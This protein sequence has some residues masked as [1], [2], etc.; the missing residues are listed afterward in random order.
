MS[1]SLKEV[2]SRQ[3]LLSATAILVYLALFKLLLHFW[4]AS[5]YGYFRDELYYIAASQHLDLGYVDFP[6]FIAV[7]TALTRWTLGDSLLALHTFPALTGVLILLLAGFMARELGGGRFAQ[8][9]AALAVLVAPTFLGSQSLLT[10]DPFDQLFWVLAAYIVLLILK[11]EDPRLWLLFG[12]VAGIG[13]LTKVTMAY[14]GLALVIGLLLTP[15]RR[16]LLSKW[17]WLGGLTALV[18]FS[19]YI[20]WQVLHGWPTLEFWRTYAVGKTYPVTPLEFLSQ[21]ILTMQPLTLPLWLAG[22]VYYFFG[23]GKKY[24]PL[25]WIY[26]ILYGVFTIQQAKNYFLAATY[27]MLFAG[28]AVLAEQFIQKRK[29]PALQP[30]CASLLLVGGMATAPL[31]MPL[32]PVETFIAYSQA[33]GGAAEV[34]QERLAIAQLP[35]HFA[36]RFGWETL[37]ASVAKVYAGLPPK[38]QAVAC[39]L[40]A[41]YGEASAIDFFGGAYYLPKAISG[42]NSYF[43]WGPDGCTGEVIITVGLRQ[44]D[45]ASSFDEVT[46]AGVSQCQYCMPYENNLPIYVGRGLKMDIR[47]VWPQA[48]HYE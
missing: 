1:R 34:R 14:F 7:I 26:V 10:M 46:P 23:G 13:L 44:E 33:F 30:A 45:L 27:P 18:L 39:I 15:N 5:Q 43:I 41:N 22:L 38:E 12:L 20:V 3:N 37:V 35:Q 8:G 11:R 36:D 42:H 31:A 9:L 19:P 4:A 24:R 29:W 17:L 48:K 32:L 16:Y 2:F 6:P 25:G 28:G 47:E 40:T 21:Q